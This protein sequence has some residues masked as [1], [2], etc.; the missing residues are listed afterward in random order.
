MDL[1]EIGT[2]SLGVT[3]FV[4]IV[5][6]FSLFLRVVIINDEIERLNR[7]RDKEI[8]EV[9]T[10]DLTVAIF[11]AKKEYITEK[12]NKLINPLIRKKGYM[13]DIL[14]FLSKK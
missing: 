13:F 9:H 8:E 10:P 11:D 2:V 4:F 12:Y 3:I 6:T 5:Y 14:P 7:A 1:N